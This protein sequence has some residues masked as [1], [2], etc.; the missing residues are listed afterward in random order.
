M[1]RWGKKHCD[2]IWRGMQVVAIC[3][4]CGTANIVPYK[5][6]AAFATCSK[7]S[8]RRGESTHLRPKS[9]R[10]AAVALRN[11]PAGAVTAPHRWL[12]AAHKIAPDGA[13]F[14]GISYYWIGSMRVLMISLI[15]SASLSGSVSP[16]ICP[17]SAMPKISAPPSVFA[18]ALMLLH[19]L[20]RELSV[21]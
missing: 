14:H 18:K 13:R 15:F 9:R 1:N 12:R 10:Y 6:F 21:L 8:P 17:S 5:L 19:Q 20:L 4:T 2:S 3:P 11:A 7:V 16:T